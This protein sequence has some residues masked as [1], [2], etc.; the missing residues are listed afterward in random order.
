MWSEARRRFGFFGG[1]LVGRSYKG[2]GTHPL[3]PLQQ[4]VIIGFLYGEDDR[5]G[6]ERGGE[7]RVY[8]EAEADIPMYNPYT[9]NHP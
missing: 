4:L 8:G 6:R 7:V 1:V 5:E 9:I 2:T 3:A